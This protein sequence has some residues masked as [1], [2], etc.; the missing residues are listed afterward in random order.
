MSGYILE[1]LSVQGTRIVQS[2]M[3]I[4]PWKKPGNN[5]IFLRIMGQEQGLAECSILPGKTPVLTWK[6]YSF[7][8]EQYQLLSQ[9][10]ER[11]EITRTQRKDF[12]FQILQESFIS[13]I[14]VLNPYH[15]T[16]LL[17]Q[18]FVGLVETGL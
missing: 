6:K 9:L 11:K 14:S 12:R 4:I 16:S 8:K 17:L 18:K 7:G 3:Q 5:R 1:K 13:K 10:K 15:F 2:Y